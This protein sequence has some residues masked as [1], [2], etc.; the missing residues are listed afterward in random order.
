M[1][2]EQRYTFE[3]ELL[4]EEIERLFEKAGKA[5]RLPEDLLADFIAD[6]TGGARAGGSDE[7]ELAEKWFERRAGYPENAFLSYLMNFELLETALQLQASIDACLISIRNTEENLKR[8]GYMRQGMFRSWTE[9]RNSDGTSAYTDKEEWEQDE[10]GYIR[11]EQEELEESREQLKEIWNNFQAEADKCGWV[12]GTMEE[13]VSKIQ[14]WEKC[15]ERQE[16]A[17]QER[18]AQAIRRPGRAR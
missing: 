13:E 9:L 3:L 18:N 12:H 11:E 5:G 7:K 6:I 1:G 16:Q 14:E 17:E 10:R 2:E 8:G 15:R 4:P